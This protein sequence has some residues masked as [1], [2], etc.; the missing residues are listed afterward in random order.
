MGNVKRIVIEVG[1]AELSLSPEDAKKLQAALNELFPKARE[2]Q[3]VP[4]P[5][6]VYPR[7][8]W[9]WSA[10]CSMDGTASSSVSVSGLQ[11]LNSSLST[12][13]GISITDGSQ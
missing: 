12:S 8:W 13:H 7:T 2:V 6:P 10:P 5:Y 1:G 4:S 9:Y 3:Y 11:L